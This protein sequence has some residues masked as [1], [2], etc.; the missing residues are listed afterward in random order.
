MAIEVYL[1]RHG[2]TV[3]NVTGERLY[4]PELTAQG[5]RQSRALAERLAAAGCT[6]VI[7]SPLIRALQTATW[8]A[9]R[10]AAPVD[11]W[12][13][14]AEYNRWDPYRG[15]G[16]A[17][18]AQRFPGARLEPDMP[19]DGWRYPGP[20]AADAVLTRACR[21]GER[22]A[23][24]PPGSRVVVVAHGNLN[25]VLLRHWLGASVPAALAQD[26]ACVNSLRLEGPG[27]TLASLNDTRHL[28]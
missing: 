2:Q 21:A 24:L 20:E 12:N 28:A 14:L 4:N 5:Q 6:R 13:D 18:L 8:V 23:A 10:L 15:A 19:E 7:A 3:G 9:E 27:V 11:V 26:N 22:L 16:R 25:G 1:V 17:A